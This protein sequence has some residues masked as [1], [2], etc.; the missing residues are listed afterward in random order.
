VVGLKPE[1]RAQLRAVAT[2]RWRLVINSLRSVR[3]RLNLVSRSIGGL[4]VGAAALGGAVALGA[5]AWE[6]TSTAKIEW[7]AVFFWIIFLFWQ[8]FP[9][10]ATAFTQNIDTSAFLRFPLTYR[11]YFL[12]RLVMGTLDIATA[13]GVCW[14]IGVL[15]GVGVAVPQLIPWAVL[16]VVA[17]IAFNVLLARMTFVWIEH[18]LSRRR[19]REIMGLFFFLVMLG[20]QFIGPALDH[21]SKKPA[22]QRFRY[23]AKLAPAQKVLPPGLCAEMLT[24]AEKGNPHWALGTFLMICA[25]SGIAFGLLHLRLR[26]Q[27]R[28]ENPEGNAHAAALIPTSVIRPGW[29]LPFVSSPVSAVFEKELHYFS[30]SGPML[31]TMI[32]PLVV[33]LVAIGGRKSLLAQQSELLFP[34]GAGYCLLV[35]TN[36]VYN[37]F[38]GDGAGIQC[39]LMSPVSFRQIVFGKNLAQLTVLVTEVLILW[40]GVC[41]IYKP[42]QLVFLVLTFCW[43]LFATPINFTVGD[44]LSL[45]SPKKIDYAVFGRQRA[46]ES[47]IFASLGVQLVVMGVGGLAIFIGYHYSDY[48]IGALILAALAIPSVAG[49]AILLRRID[50]IVMTRREVLAAD[51]FKA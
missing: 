3:G 1:A 37:S 19:S 31:F 11:T 39:F 6:L 20:F 12:V 28:G 47:T 13:L 24:A 48:W 35:M 30:R 17:F 25:Y 22:S 2:L 46:S 5:T 44:L 7:L 41:L 38:G 10:M 45:Y 50:G 34:I 21:Y 16:A 49:Y 51:L 15:V 27:F 9:L 40:L 4:V 33:V 8:F 32:V 42:P 43:Y 18:W 14:S 36:L 29:K 23:A 26:Q